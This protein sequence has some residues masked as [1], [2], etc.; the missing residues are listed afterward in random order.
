MNISNILNADDE[1]YRYKR[2]E[3]IIRY[4]G[5]GKNTKTFIVNLIDLASSLNRSSDEIMKYFSYE[6]GTQ[7]KSMYMK[8]SFTK[9]EIDTLIQKYIESFVLCTRCSLPSTYYKIKKLASE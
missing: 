6:L 5:H 4:E 9:L 7:I 2:P 1:F 3:I 8:G